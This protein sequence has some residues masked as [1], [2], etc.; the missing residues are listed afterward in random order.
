M[1]SASA[2]DRIDA[3]RARIDALDLQLLDLLNQRARLATEIG[4]EKKKAR[5]SFHVPAREQKIYQQLERCN[6]G[7]LPNQAV[8]HIFREIISASLALEKPLQVAYLG[9]RGTFTHLA[10]QKFF[11]YSAELRPVNSIKEVFESVEKGRYVYGVVP[12]ENTTEGI[13]SHTLDMFAQ[14]RVYISG[15]I[16][17]QITHDLL[18]QNSD[19]VSINKIYS[20]PQA[21]AQCERYLNR[22][23]WQ[24]E[25]AYDTAGSAKLLAAAPEP[26]VAV[27]ASRLA[28]EIYGLDI[29]ASGIEDMAFNYT[30][31]FVVQPG[32][33][34]RAENAKTSLVFATSHSPGAL[35]ACLNEFASRGINLTKLESRPR[36]GRL[37]HY[38]FYLDFEGHWQDP[39]PREALVALLARATFVKLLGSYP[40]APVPDVNGV[41]QAALLQ[42]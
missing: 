32:D 33:P 28:A 18:S 23:G 30:R 13:V 10:G 39:A 12:V 41:A 7:P 24:A 29:L 17:L 2:K 1:L 11:G 19:P 6:Q 20:H 31:F 15:E 36:R 37:W 22:Q 42:I 25:T 5:G 4:E 9:P 21:L 40:A 34:P 8:R 14:S 26:G 27:I 3:L 38:V 16:Q 35:V